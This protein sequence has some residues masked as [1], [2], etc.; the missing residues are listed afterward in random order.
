MSGTA[1][2]GFIKKQT[3]NEFLKKAKLSGFERKKMF[4]EL[5]KAGKGKTENGDFYPDPKAEKE[6]RRKILTKR[7]KDNM[8]GKILFKPKKKEGAKKAPAKKAPAPAPKKKIK[9][10]VIKRPNETLGK[11][12]TGLTKEQMNRLKPE[13]LFGKLPVEL[14]KKVLTSGPK[15]G[16][17]E[18]K[19]LDDDDVLEE[20]YT[21]ASD[22]FFE[23]L[24]YYGDYDVIPG[25]T[26]KQAQ[27]YRENTYEGLI[28]DGKR[29]AADR[30]ERIGEK[31]MENGTSKIGKELTDE[32]EKWKK[33]NKNKTFKD[34]KEALDSF[35]SFYF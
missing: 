26:E 20:F 30:Y 14:R 3:I 8:G 17:F 28:R 5:A 23:S 27:F 29:K 6:A 12:Q 9:F 11:R 2:T 35:E 33:K 18:A 34:R 19:E 13:E 21:N 31:I 32:L 24:G 1:R 15:I 4:R 7:Y 25:I 16:R 22:N 10:K